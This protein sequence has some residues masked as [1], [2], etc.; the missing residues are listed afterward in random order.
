MKKMS[1]AISESIQLHANSSYSKRKNSTVELKFVC[2]STFLLHEVAQAVRVFRK[3]TALL[4][5]PEL[6]QL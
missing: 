5:I 3:S 2:G 6:L 4:P 1:I